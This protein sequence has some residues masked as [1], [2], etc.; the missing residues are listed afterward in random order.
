MNNKLREFIRYTVYLAIKNKQKYWVYENLF[1]DGY[2][3][4]TEE[5]NAPYVTTVEP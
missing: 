1:A 5:F 3:R 2:I 4:K